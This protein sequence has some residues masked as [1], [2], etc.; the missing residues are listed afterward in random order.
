MAPR[1]LKTGIESA[2]AVPGWPVGTVFERT[3]GTKQARSRVLERTGGTEQARSS[4]FERA[5]D[6]EQAP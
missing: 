4:D 6:S 3:G 2:Q 5:G 1:R